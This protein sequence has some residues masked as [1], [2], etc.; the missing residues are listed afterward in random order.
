M[1]IVIVGAY[2]FGNVGDEAMLHIVI[3]SLGSALPNEAIVVSCVDQ[4]SVNEI[5][6]VETICGISPSSI[7]KSLIRFR[8]SDFKRQL[9]IIRQMK[10]LVY[11]GGSLFTDNKGGKNIF[12]ILMTIYMARMM[13]ANVILWGVSIGP[14]NTWF[15]KHVIKNILHMATI[16]I[17]RD[18]RSVEVAKEIDSRLENIRHGTDLLF[19]LL[20]WEDV[21]CNVSGIV[22]K[23]L[24]I[25][26]SVRPFPAIQ[27]VDYQFKDKILV[28]GIIKAIQ[29]IEDKPIEI[30]PLVFSEGTGR[31]DD[32]DILNKIKNLSLVSTFK[33]SVGGLNREEGD[34]AKNI[35]HRLLTVMSGLDVVIGER[36]HSIVTAAVV[37][38]PFIAISYDQKVSELVRACG[39]SEYC[40]EIQGEISESELTEAIVSKFESLIVNYSCI[41]DTLKENVSNIKKFAAQDSQYVVSQLSYLNS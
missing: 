36:F 8:L 9:K 28:S 32:I 6:D 19:N 24:K 29:L 11:G 38:V 25:G 39:L 33:C 31:R 22:N 10:L 15:G 18:K 3:S 5:H 16:V 40:I 1:S 2:G 4:K 27:G 14:V 21:P 37:G 26:L 34:N 17:V 23:P 12:V 41:Q 20:K 13:K 30:T 35:I 7:I